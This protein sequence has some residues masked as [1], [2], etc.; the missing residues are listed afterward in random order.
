MKPF[1]L[2]SLIII[3]LIMCWQAT[4]IGQIF[5]GAKAGIAPSFIS[6]P[7]DS[8]FEKSNPG[9]TNMLFGVILEYP[10]IY[11]FSIQPELQYVSVSATRKSNRGKIDNQVWDEGDYYS[12]FSDE[13]RNGVAEKGET[14]YIPD[15]YRDLS[16]KLHY[17]ELP[18]LFKYEFLGGE[19]GYYIEA[20]PGFS[21]AIK[22]SASSRLVDKGG[23]K[24]S[25]KVMFNASGK[26]EHN[27]T[28]LM[29]TYNDGVIGG[30]AL[31]YNPFKENK[32]TDIELRKFNMSLN[33]G[34]GMYY[35]MGTGRF[36]FDL[37]YAMGIKNLKK[38]AV[39][40]KIKTH[41]IQLSV[42]YLIPMGE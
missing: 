23:E 5:L 2:K 35:E 26:E 24:D 40:S 20:G 17:L 31:N 19:T 16:V 29:T 39:H 32:N 36:Y 6:F 3:C 9:L 12:E 22:G 10:V 27:F 1:L 28:D 15:L 8:K 41:S 18:I 42:T 14:F 7:K 21:Y 4:S 25:E 13:N 11:G 30:K 33:V 34:G 38:N 37:R